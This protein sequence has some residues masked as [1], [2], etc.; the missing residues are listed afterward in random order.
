MPSQAAARP[1]A[2][3]AQPSR[4]D[5][6]DGERRT[7]QVEDFGTAKPGICFLAAVIAVRLELLVFSPRD[8]SVSTGEAKS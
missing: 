4:R 6:L 1:R 7:L 8:G 5:H 2:S 3:A